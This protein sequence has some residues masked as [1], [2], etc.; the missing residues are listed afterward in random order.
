[1]QKI[2]VLL[3]DDH[4]ILREGIRHMLQYCDDIEI[5]GEARNGAEALERVGELQPN[6]VVMDIAMP[7]MNGIEAT[8]L[9]RE[10][11]PGTGV[12]VLSQYD[13]RQY[14]ISLL[15][16]GAS[17]YIPKHALGA[18]LVAAIRTVAR[19]EVFLYP[20]LAAIAVEEMRGHS[21]LLTHRET[22]ILNLIVQAH[23]STQIA[24]SLGLSVNTVEWHR[25]N[26][27]TK[28]DAHNVAELI[29]HAQQKGLTDMGT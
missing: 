3:A 9:I 2:R 27:M 26:L 5:V 14:V 18:D 17:G 6:V 1:V 29:R 13:D 25:A 24:V 11:Y 8:R 20:P 7:G 10:Q 12:L 15:K 16:G 23:T 28:L 19:G 22:E 21:G 4:A